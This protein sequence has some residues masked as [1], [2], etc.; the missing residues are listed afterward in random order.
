M[1]AADKIEGEG[2]K[3]EKGS[4]A[5]VNLAPQVHNLCNHRQGP[6]QKGTILV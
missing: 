4:I 6:I 2:G 1:E 5:L 3:G